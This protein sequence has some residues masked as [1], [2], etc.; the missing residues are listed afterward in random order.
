MSTATGR[1][2]EDAAAKFLKQNGHKLIAQNWRTKL[3]EIDLIT[4]KA[5]VVY[6]VEVKY[7]HSA[8]H[9]DGLDYITRA[10][11]KQMAFAA[12]YWLASS[13]SF[14]QYRLA[15][16]ALSGDPSKVDVWLDDI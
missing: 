16:V 9:G 8:T 6:F 1:K 12:E 4:Q 13:N 3:C 15:A 10:K 11:L 14:D 2:A 5:N 7:R